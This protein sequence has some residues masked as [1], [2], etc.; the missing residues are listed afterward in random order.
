M[1]EGDPPAGRPRSD[2]S[3][4]I[5]AVGHVIGVGRTRFSSD[6]R[7]ANI[8]DEPELATLIFTPENR[9]GTEEF[10]A[11]RVAVDPG[12]TVALDDIVDSL[13]LTTGIGSLEILGNVIVSSRSYA[14]RGDGIFAQ[15]VPVIES[16]RSFTIAALPE[17]DNRYNL[18]VHE[19]SGSGAIVNVAQETGTTQ[20]FIP[21]FGLRQ[22]ALDEPNVRVEVISG[23]E[24]AAYISQ[25]D[26]GG[27]AMFIPGRASVPSTLIAPAVA[28]AGWTSDLWLA[29]D[30]WLPVIGD[31]Y[32]TESAGHPLIRLRGQST[33]R[34]ILDVVSTRYDAPGTRG[35]IVLQVQPSAEAHA[36]IRHEHTSQYVP[37]L[38][39]H[40]GTEQI[41]FIESAAERRTN[42]AIV[43]AHHALAEV[44]IFDA[45]G[46]EIQRFVLETEGGLALASVTAPVLAGRA[47]VRFVEGQGW[48]GASVIDAATGDAAFFPGI[49]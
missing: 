28:D 35:A 37:F 44:V 40:A 27:D 1:F 34:V 11:V 24:I 41:L 45:S 31:D 9:D 17:P 14:F 5:A 22:I 6:V 49:R 3:Q 36:R 21:P 19:T 15:A 26:P 18:G 33:D 16:G 20:L 30:G 38:P 42:L 32:V 48:A 7:I 2:R 4:F 43:A 25:V 13:F 10:A 47:R 46:S 8:Q 12:R 39:P 23:G 29:M